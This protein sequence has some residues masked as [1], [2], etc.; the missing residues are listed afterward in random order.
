MEKL[1]KDELYI[2]HVLDCLNFYTKIT[3]VWFFAFVIMPNHL[4]II[5]EVLDPYTNENIKHNF[6]SYTAHQF[7]NK[8]SA[9]FKEEFLVNKSKRKYQFWKSPSL[10]VEINSPKF[11]EQKIN[12]LHDNPR[13][14]GLVEDNL[15]Y[16]YCSFSS[17]ELG[18]PQ[19]DFLTLFL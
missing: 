14:A 7:S 8:I 12:Y 10:S 11:L 18:T 5:Y 4:H 19:F 17:Y 13:R 3:G 1:F 6:L 16:K 15:N 2:I 9:E